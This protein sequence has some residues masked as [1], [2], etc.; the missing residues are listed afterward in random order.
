MRK[1]IRQVN[2]FPWRFTVYG[3]RLA[4]VTLLYGLLSLHPHC[5]QQPFLQKHSAVLGR[6]IGFDTHTCVPLL[7][8]PQA[9]TVS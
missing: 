7:S 2:D 8:T 9:R 5:S 6:N 3:C 4:V 1:Y